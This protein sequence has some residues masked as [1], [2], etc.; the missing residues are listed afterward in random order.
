VRVGGEQPCG[1]GLLRTRRWRFGFQMITPMKVLPCIC[2]VPATG[3]LPMPG[4]DPHL[5]QPHHVCQHWQ[6][7]G[8]N[9]YTYEHGGALLDSQGFEVQ[10][11][12]W[13]APSFGR[14]GDG[15]PLPATY[16]IADIAD[17][18]PMR[19]QGVKPASCHLLML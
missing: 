5:K 17:S 2:S 12:L 18:T 16:S 1:R 7:L 8:S 19:A 14:A 9:H 13:R 6:G 4:R 3:R 10:Y 15:S 11:R